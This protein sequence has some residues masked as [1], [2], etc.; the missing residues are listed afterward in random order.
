MVEA[1]PERDERPVALRVPKLPVPVVVMLSAPVSIEP[2]PLVMEPEFRA[3]TVVKLASVVI[4]AIEEEADN[5][6]SNLVGVQ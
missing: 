2:K 3:P 5:L 6:L 1:P 4:P